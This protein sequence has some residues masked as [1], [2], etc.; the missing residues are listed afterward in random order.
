MYVKLEMNGKALLQLLYALFMH[1]LQQSKSKDP[2]TRWSD[3]SDHPGRTN[4][5]CV[6]VIAMKLAENELVKKGRAFFD[7]Y[8]PR[9]GPQDK[10]DHLSMPKPCPHLTQWL[11]RR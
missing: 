5:G 2:G 11:S 10:Y 6:L 9:P 3:R 8:L 4:S 1:W 7:Y